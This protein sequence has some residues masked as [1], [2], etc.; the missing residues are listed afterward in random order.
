MTMRLEA[1]TSEGVRSGTV[2]TEGSLTEL[3]ETVDVLWVTDGHLAPLDG[4][5]AIADPNGRIA[6][7][8]D[9]LIV[10]VA[11]SDTTIPMHAAWHDVQLTAGPYELTGQ[12]PTLP[13]FDAAR[14]LA[15]PTGTFVLLARATLCLSGHPEAGLVELPLALVHR[16]MVERVQSDL[17]LGFYFPGA[18]SGTPDGLPRRLLTGPAA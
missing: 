8:I 9:E 11:P 6:L 4:S 15:R 7:P 17:E 18:G 13:G 10:V 3:L 2:H 16:Y 1:H 5:P 14:A 12:M